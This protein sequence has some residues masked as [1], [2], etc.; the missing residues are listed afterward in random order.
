MKLRL[1]HL[2]VP[3]AL[4]AAACAPSAKLAAPAGFAHVSGDYDDRVTSARGVVVGARIE[5]NEPRANLEFWAEAVDL[6][7]RAQG[8][9]AEEP[10]YV[11][12]TKGIPGKSLRYTY[13]DGT[14]QN[15][16][17][18]DVFATDQHV[19]LVEAAGDKGDFDAASAELEATML[20]VRAD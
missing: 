8:Y 11:T 15:R 16:Y 7:L 4:A 6:R 5:K 13:W 3:L 2:L 1:A 19:I 9:S 10:K 17:W 12:S 14:R 20:G 18:V